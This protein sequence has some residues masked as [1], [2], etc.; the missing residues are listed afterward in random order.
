MNVNSQKVREKM[1]D[2]VLSASATRQCTQS[3]PIFCHFLAFQLVFILHWSRS[4]RQF[5]E[6][7]KTKRGLEFTKILELL[8]GPPRW[9]RISLFAHVCLKLVSFFLFSPK[10]EQILA[11]T[12]PGRRRWPHTNPNLIFG[13]ES[14]KLFPWIKIYLR[15]ALPL[16]SSN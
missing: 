7:L 3:S 16:Q 11:N 5:W 4:Q 2:A 6:F 8:S 1:L 13:K 14:L 9:A 10:K 12:S 15:T